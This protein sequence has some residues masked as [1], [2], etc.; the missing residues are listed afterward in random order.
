M[1][2]P[3]LGLILVAG[4]F[5][6]AETPNE[7]RISANGG[8]VSPGYAYDG[9]GIVSA[10]ATLDGVVANAE[11]AGILNASFTFAGSAWAIQ[12]D[13][14]AQAEGKDFQDGGVA[15]ELDEHGDTGVADASLPRIHALIAAWGSARVLRDGELAAPEPWSAHLMASRDTV[16]GADGKIARADG[17]LPYDPTTPSDARRVENDPQAIL[18]VKHPQGETFS[19][20]VAPVDVTL[21]CAG[22]QCA[23][24]AQI[25]LEPGA[26][27]LALNV[28]FMPGPLPL[29]VGRGMLAFTDATGN[30]VF[31]PVTFDVSPGPTP[32]STQV[33]ASASMIEGPITLTLTGDGAFSVAIEGGVTYDDVPFLVLTWDEPVVS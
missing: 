20:G 4:C 19:R 10:D 24:S 5:G 8:S 13:R 17:V 27:L 6:A 2:A 28:S 26:A 22:P 25:P 16:R 1:R 11:N 23:Q 30:D 29:A 14:F 15:F 33:S 9:A 7:R 3:L 18:W 31:P 12:F 21:A 32:A